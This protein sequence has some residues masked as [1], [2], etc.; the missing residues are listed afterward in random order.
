MAETEAADPLPT[1]EARHGV[2]DIVRR[3]TVGP[4]ALL[5]VSDAPGTGPKRD[6]L[7]A[8]IPYAEVESLEVI[9]DPTRFDRTRHRCIIHAKGG[10]KISIPSTF[11]R[12]FADFE[13]RGASFYPFVAALAGK[14]REATP[15]ARIRAGLTWPAFL[16]Q[17]GG[18][19]TVF[20]LMLLVLDMTGGATTTSF[21][22]KGAAI[23]GSLGLLCR[24]AIRNL[25]RS[26][27]E[28]RSEP[29]V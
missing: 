7:P 17:F 9:F 13:D 4:D 8:R 23:I 25:P 24:Y 6:H 15:R 10:W 16:L 27:K 14:V 2:H 22:L 12:G 21:W 19:A 29:D 26:V 11:Y 5:R 20:L 3:W 28:P 1:H 18:P